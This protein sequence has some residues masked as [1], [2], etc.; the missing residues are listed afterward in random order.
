VA[1]LTIDLNWFRCPHGYR[2]VH[3]RQAALEVGDR[4]ETYPDED[5]IVPASS[6]RVFYRPLD[7]YDMLYM[8]FAKLGTPEKLLEFI[9]LYGPLTRTSPGRGDSIVGRLKSSRRFLDLLSSK[10]YGPKKLASRFNSHVRESIADGYEKA[11][12][13]PL[14]KDY[15]FGTL[16]VLVGTADIVADPRRGIQLRTT[17][18]TLLGGLWWQLAQKLSGETTIQSCRYCSTPFETGPGTGRHFD[19][20][21]CCDEHKVRFFSLARSKRMARKR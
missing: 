11:A 21:F 19:A 6:E 18:D 8:A 10:K 13:E 1:A 7:K 16:N 12:K 5:W 17:T 15:D 20:T 14:P 9:N 3:A 4:P 2:L